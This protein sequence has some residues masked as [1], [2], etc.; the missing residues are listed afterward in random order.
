MVEPGVFL[1]RSPYGYTWLR[2]HAGTTD[3]TPD[4]VEPPTDPPERRTS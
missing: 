1:W 2:D 3:L 4:P